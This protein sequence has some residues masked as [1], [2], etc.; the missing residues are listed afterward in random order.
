MKPYYEFVGDGKTGIDDNTRVRFYERVTWYWISQLNEIFIIVLIIS[1]LLYTAIQNNPSLQPNA[2]SLL[3]MTGF[4]FMNRWFAGYFREK[5]KDAT[6]DEIEEI[7]SKQ[8]NIE[9][10]K[11]QFIH[12]CNTHQL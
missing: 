10:L 5:V 11:E 9:R 3:I 7:L 2:I 6:K 12:L 8:E 4:G 1:S